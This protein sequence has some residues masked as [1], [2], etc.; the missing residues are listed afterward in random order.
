MERFMPGKDILG[1]F[2]TDAAERFFVR[3][4]GA[5]NLE[6]ARQRYSSLVEEFVRDTPDWFP[7]N[8]FPETGG[9]L[10]V[11][12]APGR[13][14]LGGNHTDHNHGKVLAASVQMDS[15]AIVAARQDMKV[16]YRSKGHRDVEVDLSDLAMQ[17]GEKGNSE[18]IIR[19]IAAGFREQGLNIGGFSAN[20]DPRV[21]TGSGL[22]SS[23]SMEVLL[24]RIFDSLFNGGKLSALK[25]A[26][27]GQKAENNY[28]GKPCGLMDQIAC[29]TGGAVA[30]DFENPVAPQVTQVPFDL[31]Q[32]G[33]SLCVV[34]TGGNHANLIEDY[35]AIPSE[36]KNVASIFGK[37]VLRDMDYETIL[38]NVNKIRKAAGDRALLRALHFFYENM[39]VDVMFSCLKDMDSSFLPEDK[40][41]ALGL[42]LT[43]VN[44]SGDSSWGLVQNIYSPHNPKEQGISLAL[45]LTREFIIR[46]CKGRGASRI[47]GGGFAGTIQAYISTPVLEDYRKQ[48]EAFFGP[49]SVITLSIRPVGAVEMEF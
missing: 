45:A 3:L 46:A 11:F 6:T 30:V 23:A 15:V 18:A 47:H 16:F 8:K 49:G 34:N 32:L 12:S 31:T 10:R 17:P 13:T 28:F 9:D 22:S 7:R 26:Q 33:I 25:I 21:L 4:Y 44:R 40:Q 24:G 27:I 5:E 19:G 43:Q 36:M 48:M 35:A 2:N 39:R 42:F 1:Q 41:R 29:A 14:E 20:V 38:N 37:T